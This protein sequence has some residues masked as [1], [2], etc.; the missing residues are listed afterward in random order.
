LISIDNEQYFV[1]GEVAKFI[2]ELLEEVDSYKE[3]L[4]LLQNVTGEHGES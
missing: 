3:Q 4:S 1:D 2:L